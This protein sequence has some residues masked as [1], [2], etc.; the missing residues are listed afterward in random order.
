MASREGDGRSLPFFV[1]T[2]DRH[3]F[4]GMVSLDAGPGIPDR[5]VSPHDFHPPCDG[6]HSERV[7]SKLGRQKKVCEKLASSRCSA[8]QWRSSKCL[9]VR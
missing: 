6:F 2:G 8:S 9:S 1:F 5:P 7:G 4:S 3:L